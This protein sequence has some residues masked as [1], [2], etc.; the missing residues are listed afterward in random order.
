MNI[1]RPSPVPW[2]LVDLVIEV[3]ICLIPETI[4]DIGCL[5]NGIV[6]DIF[7]MKHSIG[8][9]IYTGT[10]P[11]LS[12]SEIPLLVARTICWSDAKGQTQAPHF[13]KGIFDSGL[14][15]IDNGFRIKIG[16]LLVDNRI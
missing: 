9:F 3:Y 13:I 15:E 4:P 10:M 8:L 2:W 1:L 12:K 5:H 16:V 11:V 7:K 6:I 14:V